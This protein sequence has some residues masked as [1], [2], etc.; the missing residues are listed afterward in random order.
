MILW[1]HVFFCDPSRIKAEWI[2][3]LSLYNNQR[4]SQ[5][6]MWSTE[7]CLWGKFSN[8]LLESCELQ[9]HYCKTCPCFCLSGQYIF[10]VSKNL[11]KLRFYAMWSVPLCHMYFMSSCLHC[12]YFTNVCLLLII[13]NS[14]S[15]S[16]QPWWLI[17]IELQ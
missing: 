17:F 10:S 5:S 16:L 1:M 7:S 9:K 15:M 8:I 13:K 12:V 6:E 4:S 14:S 2:F 3:L 11:H